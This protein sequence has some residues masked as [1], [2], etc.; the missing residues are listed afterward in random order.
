MSNS[1]WTRLFKVLVQH[2]D[3]IKKCWIK[4]IETEFPQELRFDKGSEFDQLFNSHGIN[5]ILTGGPLTYKQIQQ[6]IFPKYWTIPRK[7][8][9]QTLTPF[10]YNQDIESIKVVIESSG[11]YELEI[12]NGN[13]IL[14]GYKN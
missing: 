14:Y 7:M 13:L 1:K 12:V 10:S 11:Q 5:D 6:L 8:R 9:G 4:S 2:S 3:L